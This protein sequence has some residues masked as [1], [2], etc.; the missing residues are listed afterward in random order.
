M[1]DDALVSDL[2]TDIV[3]QS[4]GP[5]IKQL[6]VYKAHYD[7]QAQMKWTQRQPTMSRF[8]REII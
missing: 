8:Q 7:T 1:D 6:D 3:Y 4:E 2:E 5:N